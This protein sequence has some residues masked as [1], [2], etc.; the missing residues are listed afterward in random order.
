MIGGKTVL[1][2]GGG[3]GGIVAASLLRKRLSRDHSVVLVERESQ[4]VF[5]PSLLW[6]MIGARREEQISRPI[7]ALAKSGIE[8]VQGEIDEI[9]PLTRRVHVGGQNILADYIVVALGAELTPETIPGLA[10]AGHN[11]Y[12]LAGAQSFDHARA[13]LRGGRVVV[14]V[15]GIPFKCPA[16]P[17][18]A[19]MLLAADARKRGMQE[20]VTVDLYTPEP[21]PMPVAGPKVSAQVRQLVESRVCAFTPSMSSPRSIRLD[22]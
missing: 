8:L 4:H 2:L 12:T 13:E 11:F 5:S 10:E 15:G 3:I 21:G 16:A 9:D 6:L 20:A 7:A 1:V 19:A 14:L 17:Y 18:E 22:A